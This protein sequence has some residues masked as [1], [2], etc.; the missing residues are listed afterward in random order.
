MAEQI[1]N[2]YARLFEVRILHHYHLDDGN[3]VF[4]VVAHPER[5]L[6]DYDIRQFFLIRPTT[7]T[8]RILAGLRCIV[9]NTAIGFVVAAPKG[10]ELPVNAQ[11][12][13]VLSVV[14]PA[15]FNYTA[16]TLLPRDIIE[17][18]DNGVNY[19]FK[20]NVFVFSNQTGHGVAPHLVLS[21]PIPTLNT[22]LIYP[23]EAIVMDATGNQLL[24][25]LGDQTNMSLSGDVQTLSTMIPYVHQDDIP[26]L[27]PP[28][29]PNKGVSLKVG[30]PDD[31]FALIHV[32]AQG[33]ATAEFDLLDTNKQPK[34]TNYP[35]FHLHFKNRMSYWR[36]LNQKDG[37][38]KTSETV[39][40]PLT[41]AGNASGTRRKPSAGLVKT[42]P[43]VSTITPLRLISEIFE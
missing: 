15:F 19:R 17:L 27:Q 18:V 9:L 1:V 24:Q 36:Y 38:L 7:D 11:F 13:F 21:N 28:G 4:D 41:Y 23:W 3:A 8:A 39:P 26:T 31:V 43:L 16:L 37:T 14:D 2:G 12:E 42:L 34:D 35:V 29:A 5:L 32:A 6:K 30:I 25:S 22:S 33:G 40:H 20:R 10:K